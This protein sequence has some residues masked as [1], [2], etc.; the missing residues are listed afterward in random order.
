MEKAWYQMLSAAALALPVGTA[1]ASSPPPTPRTTETRPAARPRPAHEDDDDDVILS[2]LDDDLLI[3]KFLI[4]EREDADE[5]FK[6]LIRR[7]VKTCLENGKKSPTPKVTF[8]PVLAP[9]PK[10]VAVFMT[11]RSKPQPPPSPKGGW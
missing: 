3:R 7:H 9:A 10:R 4:P 11:R 6:A 2:L 8:S 1:P 5:R